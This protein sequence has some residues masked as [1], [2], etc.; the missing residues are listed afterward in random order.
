MY[1]KIFYILLT[2]L[3]LIIP[4]YAQEEIKEDA[5]TIP[6]YTQEE[7]EDETDAI[8][9]YTQEEPED[10]IDSLPNYTMEELM[11]MKS[12][13]IEPFRNKFSLSLSIY[14]SSLFLEQ[15]HND[16][17]EE[18][19]KSNSPLEVGL[20]FLYGNI[21]LGF[22]TQTNL[23]YDS[24]HAKT[25]TQELRLNY[26][27]KAAV[28]EFQMKDYKGFHPDSNKDTDLEMQCIGLFGQYIWNSD[29]YSWRAAFGLYE[30]QVRSAGSLLLGGNVFYIKTERQL[31]ETYEK[32]YILATPNIGYGYTWVYDRNLFLGLSLSVGAGIAHEQ[33]DKKYYAA[34][35]NSFLTSTGYHWGDVSFMISCKMDGTVI[36]IDSDKYDSNIN[37]L[38]QCS[39][40]KRF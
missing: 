6:G 31:P 33:N 3:F 40:A 26:Y 25:E 8:P 9:Y 19:Y 20:G 12:P 11:G 28:F 4:L 36:V 37:F 27:T 17:S 21:G 34:A 16:N 22:S 5:Y 29:E 23:L 13:Y 14:K 24:D 38:T 35:T 2:S 18:S 1:K 10:D 39:V 7:L 32:K 15:V 30:K